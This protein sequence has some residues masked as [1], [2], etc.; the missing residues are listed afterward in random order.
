LQLLAPFIPNVSYGT[1][2][3]VWLRSAEF[4]IVE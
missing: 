1:P 4:E 3:R 2:L